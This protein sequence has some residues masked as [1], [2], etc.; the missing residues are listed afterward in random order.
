MS[1]HLSSTTSTRTEII[2][3][4]ATETT[5]KPFNFK[6]KLDD[7]GLSTMAIRTQRYFL[8]ITYY[9]KARTHV[10]LDMIRLSLRTPLMFPLNTICYC[11]S[12]VTGTR[13]RVND[14]YFKIS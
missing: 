10:W 5:L 14:K 8:V 13:A 3:F 7:S 11:D 2:Q 4:I 1:L 6:I 9:E 12:N